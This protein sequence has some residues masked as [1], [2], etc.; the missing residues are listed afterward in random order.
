M[1]LFGAAA[2]TSVVGK[3]AAMIRQSARLI[4]R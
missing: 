3:D 1:D 2:V 4:A